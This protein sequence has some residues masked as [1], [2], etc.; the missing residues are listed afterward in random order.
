MQPAAQ[1]QSDSAAADLIARPAAGN[2]SKGYILYLMMYGHF[3]L[4]LLATGRPLPTPG[5]AGAVDG[6]ENAGG[7]SQKA[8]SWVILCALLV[9][10]LAFSTVV[11]L[12]FL[13]IMKLQERN[14]D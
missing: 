11:T 7:E 4:L 13:G 14:Y 6:N 2:K 10:S 8:D 9:I 5:G 12:A 1:P 3:A